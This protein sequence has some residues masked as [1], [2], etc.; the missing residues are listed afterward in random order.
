MDLKMKMIDVVKKRLSYDEKKRT[1]TFSKKL[2]KKLGY[3]LTAEKDGKIRVYTIDDEYL[4]IPLDKIAD[5]NITT[6]SNINYANKLERRFQATTIN[7]TFNFVPDMTVPYSLIPVYTYFLYKTHIFYKLPMGA[8]TT[9]ISFDMPYTG[10]P[11]RF[12]A[13][14]RYEDRTAGNKK[15]NVRDVE[16]VQ[17]KTIIPHI[18]KENPKPNT[19]EE[20]DKNDRNVEDTTTEK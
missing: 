9:A 10:R 12:S 5:D 20:H 16:C 14:I 13:F 1:L 2:A 3:W 11:C 6:I 17:L 15:R 8:G 7:R 4:V 19:Q 18:S